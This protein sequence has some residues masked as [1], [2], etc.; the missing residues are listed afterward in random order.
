MYKGKARAYTNIALIKYWGKENETL[1]LPMNNS[2]SLTLDAFYTE[3]SVTFSEE[4][5]QDRFFLDDKQQSEAATKKVSAF[6]D[7]VRAKANCPF[8]AQVN[9]R[10][11]VP[12]AAGLASSASGLAALA[13]ACNA[14]LDLQ[15]SQTELS[16][17]ARRGS[18]SACRSIFGG[19]VEWHTGD[20]NTS[21]ATPIASEGWEKELSMLFILIN[22]KEKDVS[23]RD[24]MRRT[25][26][27]SSYYS[28]WLESTPHDLKKLKQAIREKDFQL[29]GET[30]E[31]NALKMHATT[32]AATP[33]FT[34]WSPESLRAMDCVRSLRQKGLA[35]YFTMDAGPNVK[36]LC[37]RKDEEAILTQLKKDFHP[38]QLIVAH[39]GQG[40]VD[41]PMTV[42]D[43]SMTNEGVSK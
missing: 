5:T 28:G 16:R 31:A 9:S 11:F 40:L 2:L 38:E 13:G 30:T 3:T 33:P 35:C 1:I 32:M 23:S 21:Y 8:F 15:L 41:L 27:T 17:L 6:L 39:A 10:N 42:T 19:F 14:A 25:V 20:D 29:L 43:P 18:G 12:T 34:Y 26:E 37:Q 36:V 22:D 4:Y 24:G 7:L